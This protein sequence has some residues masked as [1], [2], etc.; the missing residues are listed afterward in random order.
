MNTEATMPHPQMMPNG[1]Y[2]GVWGGYH[3]DFLVE[4]ALYKAQ[5]KIGI[6]T[7]AAKCKVRICDGI[8]TVDIS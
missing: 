2:D 7:P 8:V 6:R 4:G 1:I 5:T 3:V